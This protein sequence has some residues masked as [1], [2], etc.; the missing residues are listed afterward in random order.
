MGRC[1]RK[2]AIAC[3]FALE[4]AVCTIAG[5][6]VCLDSGGG[7][8]PSCSSTGQRYAL[9]AVWRIVLSDR[10]LPLGPALPCTLPRP[11][12]VPELSGRPSISQANPT[13]TLDQGNQFACSTTAGLCAHCRFG[14]SARDYFCEFESV[15]WL[16]LSVSNARL[17]SQRAD[18]AALPGAIVD[19]LGRA[20]L[21]RSNP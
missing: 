8:L 6:S 9:Y 15:D 7:P 5:T 17:R 10:M 16:V 14:V 13:L 20:T 1:M 2:C 12:A 19:G 3:S 11:G 18:V 4:S 21:A